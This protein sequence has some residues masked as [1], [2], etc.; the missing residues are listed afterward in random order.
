MPETATN[1]ADR[2]LRATTAVFAVALFVHG[3]DHF[4]RGLNVCSALVNALGTLQSMFA[5]LTIV[6]VFRG[7]RAA[8]LAAT[9]VGFASAV[10]F[11]VVHILPDWFGPLSDSFINPPASARV[12][13]FS[14]FAALFEITADLAVGI[15]GLYALRARRMALAPAPVS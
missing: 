11:L 14:W 10:G 13:G 1:P 12:T 7:H 6:L 15:A 8:P 3:A 4:R 2:A 9:I 5:V